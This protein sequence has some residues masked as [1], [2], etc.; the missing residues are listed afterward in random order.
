M[1]GNRRELPRSRVAGHRPGPVPHRRFEGPPWGRAHSARFS[2]KGRFRASRKLALF[3]QFVGS[4][5]LSVTNHRPDGD[6]TTVPGEWHFACALGGRAIQ[7]VWIAPSRAERAAKGASSDS[8]EWG[9]TLRLY[10]AEIDA[11]RVTWIG[12]NHAV[13]MPSSLAGSAMKSCSRDLSRRRP[14]ALDLLGD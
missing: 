2:P 3:G 7:D 12:P 8:G 9:S 14:D 10:D 1:T 6:S 13:V 4:W 5:D 11:W